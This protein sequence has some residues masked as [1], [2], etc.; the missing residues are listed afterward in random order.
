M[1]VLASCASPTPTPTATPVPPATATK[2]PAT[3][4]PPTATAT[5]PPATLVPATAAPAKKF[6]MAVVPP[7]LVSPFYI[8]L[9]D[10]CKSI[11]AKNP[12]IDL[13][14]IA[15]T[16]QTAIEEQVKIVEDL[17]QRKVNLIAIA[18][19]NWD[20]ITPSLKKAREAGID[21]VLVD[22]VIP[23]TGVDA[24]SALGSDEIEGGEFVGDFVNKTW[25][26]KAK[27]AVLG[28]V[29]GSYHAERRMQG[30]K[31]KTGSIPGIQIVANQPANWDRGV[32]MSTAENILQSQSDLDVIWG[33]NDN[34]ALGAMTAVEAAKR[35]DKVKIIGYNGDK[36]ALEMVKA[37]RMLA[38]FKSQPVKI[39]EAI[40]NEIVPSLMAGKRGDIKPAYPIHVVPV[41]KDNVDQFLQ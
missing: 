36:E 20:A 13:T 29:V 16:A 32:G 7:A 31:N 40:M 41:T 21:I 6:V 2:A 35:Q 26:G 11:A 27:V 14:V 18:S 1:L 28:G 5:K 17:T 15:P 23:L 8:V 10:T 33:Q 22:R 38:T 24:I 39:A 4:V 9:S 34:M 30:F 19:S 3:A 12:N 37:G 25:N